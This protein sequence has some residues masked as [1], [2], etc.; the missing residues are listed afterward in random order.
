MIM[1]KQYIVPMVESNAYA[2]MGLLMSSGDA[3]GLSVSSNLLD[4]NGNSDYISSAL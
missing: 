3:K 2:P 1:K 4:F